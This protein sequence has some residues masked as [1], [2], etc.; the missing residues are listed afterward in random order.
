MHGDD[1]DMVETKN[2]RI[3]LYM[4][5][6]FV[7][8]LLLSNLIAGKLIQVYG[9]VLPAAVI[10]FPVTYILGD[11]FVEVY[12]FKVS[13]MII[14]CG[15]ACNLIAVIAYCITIALPYPEY[16]ENQ[17]AYS[18][19]LGTTPRIF[20]AS[21]AGYLLGEFLNSMVLS[22]MKV[23]FK[24]RMLWLRTITSSVIGEGVDTIVFILI[25]FYGSYEFNDILQ[26]MAFQYVF[27]LGY[28]ILLTPVTCKI[29]NK[30]KKTVGIDVFD[31]ETHYNLFK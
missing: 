30:A 29:I 19:V 27:K 3:F 24:G 21:I 18:T 1:L 9:I 4:S 28:E 20:L 15:F 22:K 2:N 16:W 25:S 11:I 31:E 17:E 10:L 26:M 6:A 13:R 8:L 23:R 7:T 12:G 14:W 5:I